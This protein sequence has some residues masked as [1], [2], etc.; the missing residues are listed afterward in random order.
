MDKSKKGQF[1]QGLIIPEDDDDYT[2]DHLKARLDTLSFNKG[3]V[4]SVINH[5]KEMQR[6][7]P[8]LDYS[9]EID[10]EQRRLKGL[11]VHIKFVVQQ[12]AEEE[13]KIKK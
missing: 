5:M 2:V 4:I 10:S 13:A 9:Q 3:Q 7:Y 8:K 11:K 1:F 6:K 12:I